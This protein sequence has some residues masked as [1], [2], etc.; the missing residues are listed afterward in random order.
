MNGL[1]AFLAKERSVDQSRLCVTGGSYGGFNRLD[2]HH[3]LSRFAAAVAQRGVYDELN[4][5]GSGDIPESVEWYYGGFAGGKFKR[6]LGI[7]SDRACKNV[8]TPLLILHSELDYRCPISRQRAFYSF[9]GETETV[10]LIWFDFHAK[11]IIFQE[12]RTWHRIERLRRLPNGLDHQIKYT[13]LI[14]EILTDDQLNQ[15]I[16]TLKGWRRRI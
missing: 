6:T 9:K 11:G 14:D 10:M 13:S 8:T 2:R 5:F 12:R 4:M 15:W 7:F 16:Y 1:D 3:I